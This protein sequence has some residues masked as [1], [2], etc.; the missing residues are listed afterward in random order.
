M[1]IDLREY[2]K[3]MAESALSV[4]IGVLVGTVLVILAGYSPIV[5][6]KALFGG[7]FK[8]RNAFLD[9]LSYMV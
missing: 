9:M 6:F 7:S 4:L 3:P 8:S 1:R 2:A 5:F